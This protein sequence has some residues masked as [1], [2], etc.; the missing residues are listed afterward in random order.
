[1]GG[2]LRQSGPTTEQPHLE[3]EHKKYR[4]AWWAVVVTAASILIAAGAIWLNLQAQQKL[5]VLDLFL[6]ST[7]SAC[8]FQG[9][10]VGEIIEDP[11]FK[12]TWN[13]VCGLAE[14]LAPP[15]AVQRELATLLLQYPGKRSEILAMYR[16]I[17]SADAG[18]I[19]NLEQASATAGE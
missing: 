6:N 16:V 5:L 9:S 2:P 1:M 4:Q 7:E 17:Y 13:N 11:E 10:V 12:K 18:W 19:E 3:L 14:I 8:T 15:R